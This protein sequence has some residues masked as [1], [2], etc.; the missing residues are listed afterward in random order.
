[1]PMQFFLI[2]LLTVIINAGMGIIIPILPSLLTQYGFT[3]VGLSLPFLMLIA[4]RIVSKYYASWLLQIFNDKG[5]LILCFALYGG[6]FF[7]YALIHSAT[8]LMAIRFFEGLVEGMAIICL[9]DMA[10]VLSKENRGKRLGLFGSA[11]GLGFMLG[12]AMGGVMYAYFGTTGMFLTGSLLGVLGFWL[13][14]LLKNIAIEQHKVSLGTLTKFSVYWPFLGAY[15]PSLLR[16]CLFFAF[17]ILIPLYGSEQL[18]LDV[19]E[20]AMYFSGSAIITTL[21]MPW[22][23]KLADKCSAR[24]ITHVTLLVMGM[25]IMAFGF[26]ND[27]VIFSGLFMVETLMFSFMMPAGMKVFADVVEFHPARKDIVGYFGSITEILTLGL[28]VL[29]PVLYTIDAKLSWGLLAMGCFAAAI[30][31]RKKIEV[32]ASWKNC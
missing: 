23:G 18:G 12:P 20:I 26:T 11:F 15:A 27:I 5:V 31:F 19:K 22:T 9:T 1:M 17:M 7:I 8:A 21:L 30:P 3:A 13:C 32:V 10:I 29:V 2:L 25:M 14:F 28:A 6:V 4:G 16:R 24:V